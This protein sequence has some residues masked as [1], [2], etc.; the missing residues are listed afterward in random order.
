MRLRIN[1]AIIHLNDTLSK[2]ELE[3]SN[4]INMMEIFLAHAIKSW[5]LTDF[6]RQRSESETSADISCFFSFVGECV[7][8]SLCGRVKVCAKSRKQVPVLYHESNAGLPMDEEWKRKKR[9]R[10]IQ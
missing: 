6:C 2:R 10:K 9:R 8:T 4:F 5:R 3:A 7:E 1:D